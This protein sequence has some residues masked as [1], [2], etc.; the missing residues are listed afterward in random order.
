MRTINDSFKHL[1]QTTNAFD[2]QIRGTEKSFKNM[3][4]TV[5][6]GFGKFLLYRHTIGIIFQDIQNVIRGIGHILNTMGSEGS[7]IINPAVSESNQ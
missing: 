1:T 5:T 2:S 7:K 3:W 4:G 6:I